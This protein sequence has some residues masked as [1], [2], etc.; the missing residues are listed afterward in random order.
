M[1]DSSHDIMEE[2]RRDLLVRGI[3]AAKAKDINEAHF[4]LN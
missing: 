3:A 4:Y 2:G 1:M